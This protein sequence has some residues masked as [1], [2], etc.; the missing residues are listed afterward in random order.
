MRKVVLEIDKLGLSVG[1]TISISLVD[2]MGNIATQEHYYNKN[3]IIQEPLFSCEL[4]ENDLLH[5]ETFY[6]LTLP[7]KEQFNFRVHSS[8]KSAPLDMFA[9]F[10]LGCY[11][12]II[13]QENE[14]LVV[15]DAKFLTELEKYFRGE[16]SRFTPIE[17]NLVN[18]YENYYAQEIR[19]SERTIDAVALLDI[20]LSQ[21][22]MK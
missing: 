22:G 5:N 10:S 8:N 20:Y 16:S 21:K 4:F 13:R 1:D 11:D 7:T 14:E 9:L 17:R 15:V 2:K 6:K 3:F 12:S 19:P 18:L